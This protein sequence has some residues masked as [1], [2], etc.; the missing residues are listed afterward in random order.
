MVP[1]AVTPTREVQLPLA[2]E[3]VPSVRVPP[4]TVPEAVIFVTLEIAPLKETL[5]PE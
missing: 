2:N 4:V 3:A 1:E 5:V